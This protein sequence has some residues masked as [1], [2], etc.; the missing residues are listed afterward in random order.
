MS[1][2]DLFSDILT[3]QESSGKVL[4]IG[5]ISE[6]FSDLSGKDGNV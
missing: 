1:N 5:T 3:H 2:D 6:I 4:K